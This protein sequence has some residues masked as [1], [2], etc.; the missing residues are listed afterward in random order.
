M[1]QD[2][3]LDFVLRV[4]IMLESAGMTPWLCGG[5]A[6]ELRGLRPAGEHRDV[7]LLYPAEGFDKVDRFLAGNS[8]A[9]EILLKRFSHKRAFELQRI[10][11]EVTLVEQ[12]NGCFFTSYFSGR[13]T[14]RWPDDT[15]QWIIV[16]D[17]FRL[18]V[19]S[20]AALRCNRENHTAVQQAYRDFRG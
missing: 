18:P 15:F 6:E 2:N 20:E 12:E 14:V 9:E 8:M 16:G 17:D 13:H 11:I 3:D 19:A 4:V 7:D 1:P 5:W 10:M